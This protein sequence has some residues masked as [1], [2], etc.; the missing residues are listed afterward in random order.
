MNCQR[1]ETVVSELARGQMMAAEQKTEAL[2]HSDACDDC[3]ARLNDEQMLTLGLQSLAAEL[4]SLEAPHEVEAKLLEAFRA[5]TVVVPITKRSNSRYWLAAIA[6]ML[7]IA[8]SVVVF[9][10][11]NRPANDQR[12]AEQQERLPKPQVTDKSNGQ[13]ARDV[14]APDVELPQPSK[15]KRVRPVTSRRANNASV[16]NHVTKE[17]ATDFIPL[18]YM[19]AASLQ[20]GGQIIRVQV[21]RSALANFGL[22]VNMDR[23]NEKVKADVLYG[24]D[25]MARAIRFVQ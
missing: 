9:R 2:A 17:I 16:A 23:Y 1:F 11:N 22:P 10:W 3:A 15:P 6:A 8:I 14:E 20:E 24:V 7:L 4:E 12:Q 21:P 25:G 5:R 18:S 19:S 13:V